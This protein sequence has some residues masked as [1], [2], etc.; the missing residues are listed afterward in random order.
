MA[1]SSFMQHGIRAVKM[2]DIAQQLAISKRTLYEIYG[3]K[4]ELLYQSIRKYDQQRADYLFHYAAAGH[5]VIDVIVEAYRRRVKEVHMVNPLFYEDIMKYPKVEQYIMEAHEKTRSD[6]YDFMRQGVKE[7]LLRPDIDYTILSHLLDAIGE[8]VM[9]NQ[10]LR[11]YSVEQ[12]FV[13][14][15]LVSLRGICTE[16]GVKAL[17]AAMAKIQ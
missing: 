16:E 10:L 12:L 1:M 11:R 5:H 9:S 13:N 15:F 6:F 4:E 8:Y 3:D 17:D 7:G 2:D 14:F